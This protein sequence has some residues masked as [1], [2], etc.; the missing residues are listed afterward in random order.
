M[1]TVV[2]T[3]LRALPDRE[4]PCLLLKA[5][6]LRSSAPRIQT[7][8]QQKF[9]KSGGGVGGWGG[10]RHFRNQTSNKVRH[11]DHLFYFSFRKRDK[12]WGWS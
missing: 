9:F 4:F 5:Q 11:T 2:A 1:G 6:E 12:P 10:E 7:L 3:A 8:E